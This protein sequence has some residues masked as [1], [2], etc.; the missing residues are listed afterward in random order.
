MEDKH[1]MNIQKWLQR[2]NDI[3]ALILYLQN[4][5]R[6]SNDNNN[7]NNG[8]HTDSDVIVDDGSNSSFAMKLLLSRL[9]DEL[10]KVDV[11]LLRIQIL[12]WNDA[13]SSSSAMITS[14][15]GNSTNPN[16]IRQVALRALDE[17]SSIID[18]HG[19]LNSTEL[20]VNHDVPS[21]SDLLL[22]HSSKITNNTDNN[23]IGI[24]PTLSTDSIVDTFRSDAS[25]DSEETATNLTNTNTNTMHEYIVLPKHHPQD[26]HDSTSTSTI[27][28]L[29]TILTRITIL[30]LPLI[31]SI[32]LFTTC[33]TAHHLYHTYGNPLMDAFIWTPERRQNE[34]TY[35]QRQCHINDISTTDINDIIINPQTTSPQQ[36]ADITNQHGMA[37]FPYILSPDTIHNMREFVL[38]KNSELTDDDAI[39][40]ISQH[41]RWSFPISA[42]SDDS[43]PP[44]LREIA[45]NVML[46]SSLDILLGDDPAMVEFTAIT[47]AYGAGD[48]HWH[49]DNSYDDGSMHFGRSFV[50]MYSL[51]IPLQDTTRAMGATSA[52]PGTHL[53]GDETWLTDVC[54]EL[55]FQVHDSRGDDLA[56]SEMDH[57]WKAGDG[58][59]M[60]LNTFH[61]GP[62]HTDPNG[63]ERVMLIMSISSR[64]KGPHFDRRQISLGTSYSNSWDMWSLTMKDLATIENTMYFP[65]NILRTLGIYKPNNNKWGFD[66]F[67]VAASRIVNNQMGYR[68]DDLQIFVDKLRSKGELMRLL[69]GYLPHVEDEEYD[70]GFRLYFTEA[71]RR[72]IMF[73]GAVYLAILFFNL[74]VGIVMRHGFSSLRR[75]SLI[76]VVLISPFVLWAYFLSKT[77]WGSDLI[78]GYSLLSPFSAVENDE[79]WMISRFHGDGVTTLAEGTDVLIGTRL[80]SHHLGEHLTLNNNPGNAL[81]RNLVHESSGVYPF[82]ILREAVANDISRNIAK[83][84]GRF[85][86]Q[87]R[88][89]DWETLSNE[90][91]H[92]YISSELRMEY[93]PVVRSAHEDIL[94][95]ISDCAYGPRRSTAMSR[96][97]CQHYLWNMNEMLLPIEKFEVK[98][99]KK[100]V[101]SIISIIPNVK[102]MT[103][104]RNNLKNS[105]PSTV[106]VDIMPGDFIETKFDDG[107]F[108][109]RV[110][111]INDDDTYNV[112]YDDGDINQVVES[113][114]R[115]AHPY[116]EG[117]VVIINSNR[118]TAVVK[119]AHASGVLT[120]MECKLDVN[121]SRALT[122]KDPVSHLCLGEPTFEYEL[123]GS[124]IHRKF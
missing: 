72:C 117:D 113:D 42:S 24:N 19:T 11:E 32:L 61:R 101:K 15:H 103:E 122:A 95:L 82:D 55:D 89:G 26:H 106:A 86:I 123:V 115:I 5:K 120:V 3:H 12:N 1:D 69:F 105:S 74:F 36:A 83:E 54:D 49:S 73:G 78:H 31:L 108:R 118:A 102:Q 39:P 59:L 70:G 51:F 65:W 77:P 8:N 68:Y 121:A 25:S 124:Q 33:I 52:C 94:D 10:N 62:A 64:P 93:Y 40:L 92:K 63:T 22:Q 13:S 29:F 112:V 18:N 38:C 110:T 37:I 96:N 107:W 87:N 99:A 91:I 81:F 67:T 21:S 28:K 9:Q 2:R 84:R 23:N 14:K 60:H 104:R 35:F 30:D 41:Q 100:N 80:Q 43:V 7:I 85:L 48:Q 114:A 109:G 44:V 76:H 45:T 47:S 75:A 119:H 97:Q 20:V 66:L 53:C 111:W 79:T 34:Y 27:R 46:Q 4:D 88:Y 71:I 90:Q 6:Y 116:S 16:S 50:P 58:F 56:L 57:V 17:A 98:A